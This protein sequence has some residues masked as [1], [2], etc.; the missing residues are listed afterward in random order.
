MRRL[1]RHR[2]SPAMIVAM[3]ALFVAL[4]GVSYAALARNSVGPKQL[5][6]N[7]VTPRKIK[8]NAVTRAKIRP[9]AINSSRVQNGSLRAVDFAAGQLPT[10]ATGPTGPTGPAGTALAYARVGADGTLEPAAGQVKNIVQANI[11]HPSAGIY[12]FGGLSFTPTSAQVTNDS[13]GEAT[14][15]NQIPSIAV[16]RGPELGICGAEFQQAR[17][18]MLQVN[19]TEPPAPVDHRFYVWFEGS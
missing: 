2:P 6:R 9:N 8:R 12:C 4:S 10:G 16:F 11:E 5:K 13:A 15:S 14:T 17:V 7:A 19:D 3:I 1:V 18:T